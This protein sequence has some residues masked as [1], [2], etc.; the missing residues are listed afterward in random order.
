MSSW[1]STR[2]TWSRSRSSPSLPAAPAAIRS[3]VSVRRPFAV[4]RV[5]RPPRA[6]GCP[7]V[8]PPSTSPSSLVAAL[9]ALLLV[10]RRDGRH[11]VPQLHDGDGLLEQEE[12]RAHPGE[13]GD[14]R[15]RGVAGRRERRHL[16]A[17]A[18]E[19]R[20]QEE[21]EALGADAEHEERVGEGVV[22]AQQRDL[23]GGLGL[24]ARLHQHGAVHLAPV[25]DDVEEHEEEEDQEHVRVAAAEQR[26]E[27]HEQAGR[28]EAIRDHVQHAAELG[29]L[30]ERPRRHAVDGV[31]HLARPVHREEHQVVVEGVVERQQARHDAEVADEVGHEE[32]DGHRH[33]VVGVGVVVGRRRRHSDFCAR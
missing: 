1:S 5:L 3:A 27:H 22:E 23:V 6:P 8:S 17:G 33:G 4:S 10:E 25:A 32:R 13:H 14:E 12:G 2:A 26:A 7:T 15:G 31:K 19:G 28:A 24:V 16:G 30:A 9:G 21:Q 18:K 20:V 29:R 11:G